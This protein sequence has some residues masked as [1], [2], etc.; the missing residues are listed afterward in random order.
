MRRDAKKDMMEV[1]E[2][3]IYFVEHKD[4]A[5]ILH[6][7]DRIIDDASVYQDDDIVTVAVI[8]YA[9]GNIIERSAARDR[10]FPDF[11]PVL[12]S[13]LN[14]LKKDDLTAFRVQLKRLTNLI[15]E[16][17]DKMKLYIQEVLEKAKIRRASHIHKQGISIARTSELLGIS[18]WELQDFVGVTVRKDYEGMRVLDRLGFARDNL[19]R[20][21]FDA[22]PVIALTANNL[23]WS[24]RKLGCE[25]LLPLTV[26]REL[27]ERGLETRRFKFEALQV[28]GLVKEGTFKVVDDKK[29]RVLAEEL[30]ALANSI[31]SFKRHKIKIVDLGEMEVL[32]VALLKKAVPVVDERV[33]RT[34]IESPEHIE[35][36]MERRLRKDLKVDESKLKRFRSKVKALKI[37]RS[38]EIAAILFE[39]GILDAYVIDI[40]HA[41]REL[42]ESIL[43]G[44]KTEGCSVT[45]EEIDE[46]VKNLTG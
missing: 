15:D 28:G 9:L 25:C 4:Y 44:M 18:Q 43:W 1:I 22:G 21:V 24:F 19:D 41:R 10:P 7:S 27:V 26:K 2:K 35:K 5:N 3:V 23:L 42:L 8:V 40:P 17:D 32:A 30:L 14:S 29:V 13:A 46:V 45:V 34:L 12:K 37:I 36:L 38:V 31:F 20:L 11:V 6:W 33:T 39:R 16:H